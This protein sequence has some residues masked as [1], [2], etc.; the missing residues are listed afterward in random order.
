MI[1]VS[2]PDSI[3]SDS[4]LFSCSSQLSQIYK[5]KIAFFTVLPYSRFN[6]LL[7]FLPNQK[8]ESMVAISR[9]YHFGADKAVQISQAVTL[10]NGHNPNFDTKMQNRI[11]ML[12]PLYHWLFWVQT[13]RTF[14]YCTTFSAHATKS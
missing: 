4:P 7:S 2:I 13:F 9:Q 5:R 12:N 3:N 10:I 11:L 14:Q 8:H 6:A 1:K